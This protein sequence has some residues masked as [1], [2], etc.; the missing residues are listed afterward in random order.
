MTVSL[1]IKKNKKERSLNKY[2][3]SITNICTVKTITSQISIRP[4]SNKKLH[5][6][7]K[8]YISIGRFDL[9]KLKIEYLSIFKAVTSTMLRLLKS[10]ILST[11]FVLY[12]KII[13]F[14][15]FN[16]IA[17]ERKIIKLSGVFALC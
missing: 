12:A 15:K 3:K 6:F 1:K 13:L 4:L 8:R 2:S 11:V 16:Q 17:S 5:N 14:N 9:F 10:E 7:L